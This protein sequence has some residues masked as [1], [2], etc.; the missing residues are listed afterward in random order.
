[1]LHETSN[2]CYIY[3]QKGDVWFI[4]ICEETIAF[5]KANFEQMDLTRIGVTIF[6]KRKRLF[7]CGLSTKKIRHE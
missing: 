6:T 3:L 7:L 5:G 4:Y 2:E 1:M